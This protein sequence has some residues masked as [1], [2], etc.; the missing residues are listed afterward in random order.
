[1]R[2]WRPLVSVIV[3]AACGGH[4]SGGAVISLDEL[5]AR[6]AAAT[7]TKWFGCC[8][9]TEFMDKTL[10]AS[11]EEECETTFAGLIDSLLVPTLR[12]SVAN[13]RLVYHGDV[14]ADCLA[15]YDDLSCAQFELAQN[16]SGA[17]SPCDDPFEGLVADAGACANDVDCVSNYCSGDSVGSGGAI[18]FGA[19][20]AAPG[21]GTPC[22]DGQCIDGAFCDGTNCQAKLADGTAC[23]SDEECINDRCDVAT[24]QC[25]LTTTCDGM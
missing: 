12:D 20:R 2:S 3:L 8:N 18:T 1:M 24:N 19:C 9:A 4:G 7:C 25:G 11:T 6:A 15:T 21:P 5:A 16:V 23:T 22:D 13:G 10:G 17:D 14:M